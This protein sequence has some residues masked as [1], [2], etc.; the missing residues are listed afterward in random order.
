MTF[1]SI[2]LPVYKVQGYLR[3]CLDSLLSQS[4]ADFEIVAVDDRSPDYSGAILAEYAARDPRVRVVTAPE[5]LGLGRARNL[6]LEHATGEYVWFVDSDDWLSPGSLAAVHDRLRSTEADLLIVGWDRVHWDGRVQPGTARKPLAEAPEVFSAEQWPRVLNI[7][8]VAWNKVVRRDFLLRLGFVFEAG[9]YED[10]SFSFPV[11]LAA[12]RISTLSRT[13]VHYRQRRTG[14]ITRT[15]GDRH[16]EVF[17][18]WEHAQALATKYATPG[19][20]VRGLLFRRMIWHF[21]RVLRHDARVPRA[22]RAR[23][24]ARMHEMYQQYLP[25]GGYPAPGRGEGIR[26]QLVARGSY[27]TMRLF[28]FAVGKARWGRRLARRTA[29][30]VKRRAR[31]AV[32]HLYY[33]TQLRL[34][35]DES[36]A[37][38]GAYW[39]RGVSCN[40][41]AIATKAAELA[42]HVRH[43]WVVAPGR[44]GSLPP[45]TDHVVAGSLPYYRALARA[46]YLIN[47]VN[48][49]H[50]MV[51]RRG[52]THVMTHHGTPLKKMG[53]DQVD[54]PAGVRDPDFRAQMRRADRW[55][56]SVTANAHTTVAWESA[57]P[58]GYETLEVGYPRNDR[59]AR[60]T[61]ADS[62]AARESLGIPAGRRVVLFMPTHRE[63][64]P[65]GRQPIDVERLADAVGPDTLLL[66]R[67]HYF[68]TGTELTGAGNVV[69]VSEHPVV[70]DLY[71]AADV[72]LTDYSSAMF[73]FAVLDRPIIIFAPD[74]PVYRD[75]RGTYFDLLAE[76]P[77]AVATDFAGLTDLFGRGAY[78]DENAEAARSAFRK[79][80]CALDDGHAA[81]RVVRR[82]FLSN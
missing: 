38:Y 13:C 73:D 49:P 34:P 9:W 25:P 54:H 72:L 15:V 41:A 59:L 39:F 19:D 60:A 52:T 65:D 56:L 20:E 17:D 82:V 42:P 78:T 43:L 29:G 6:G 37:L 61:A 81:E 31:Q 58:C 2:V 35:V 55:D 28:D 51:K 11:M 10:V 63:W 48:W 53:A 76:P 75:L 18:H 46:R 21:L 44:A 68:S 33:R 24:F 50:R 40:P 3:Q 67:K 77:G 62:A 1:L 47:N 74:W 8:H 16:F 70:E 36:L 71:L 5:N 27:R 80:F 64:L 26:Y 66:V 57:Y 79:R 30:F 14:A 45:G 4:F 69:D 23:F 7:L 32:G 12:P 22:S